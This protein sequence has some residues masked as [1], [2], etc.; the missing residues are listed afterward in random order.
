MKE[1]AF[2]LDFN[3]SVDRSRMRRRLSDKSENAE[4]QQAAQRYPN[5]TD[6]DTLGEAVRRDERL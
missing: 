2:P 5:A 1:R 3:E 4:E 6:R